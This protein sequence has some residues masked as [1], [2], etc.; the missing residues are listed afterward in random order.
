MF[1]CEFDPLKSNSNIIFYNTSCWG[2]KWTNKTRHTD[3]IDFNQKAELCFEDK[4][5]LHKCQALFYML[6]FYTAY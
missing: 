5:I 4:S 1:C 3:T 2:N 6:Q